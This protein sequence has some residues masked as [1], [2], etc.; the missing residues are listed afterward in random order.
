MSA[1]KIIAGIT[2]VIGVGLLIGG[3]FYKL[4]F[5]KSQDELL[6]LIQQ[7]VNQSEIAIDI[8]DKV[9]KKA[10]TDYEKAS[11]KDPEQFPPLT[12]EDMIFYKTNKATSTGIIEI[13]SIKVKAGVI[14]GVSP[15]ELAISAGRYKTSAT[16]DMSEGNLVVAGHVS[17]PVP[18]FAKLNKVKVGDEIRYTYKGITYEY[19]VTNKFIAQPTQVEILDC[20]PGKK[21][22]TVFTCANNGKQ[23]TVIQAEAVN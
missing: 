15:R 12:E 13:P 17:G 20:P 7:N 4:S 11:K 18:V 22:L 9:V 5:N 16:P 19:I 10:L 3:L 1:K 8:P 23:R 14:E 2:L 6:S 21:M